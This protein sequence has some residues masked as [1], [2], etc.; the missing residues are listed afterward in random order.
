M[1]GYNKKLLATGGQNKKSGKSRQKM[2]AEALTN[3]TTSHRQLVSALSGLYDRKV[4][5]VR[6]EGVNACSINDGLE[7]ENATQKARHLWY[8][9][10]VER[11]CH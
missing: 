4:C 11:N 8:K 9:K 7:K 1:Q 2:Q 5:T 3:F 6:Y 10:Q